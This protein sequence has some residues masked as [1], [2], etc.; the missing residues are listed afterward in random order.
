MRFLLAYSGWVERVLTH[1]GMAAGWLFILN[2]I[3]ICT[4][5][6]TRKYG[7]QI[8]GFGSTRLQE[9]EWHLHAILFSMWMGL[10]YLRNAH[11]RIDLMV[12]GRSV[13]TRAW[14]EFVCLIIFALPY[15][16]VLIDHGFTFAWRSWESGEGSESATGLPMRWIAKGAGLRCGDGH[17]GTAHRLPVR[18]GAPARAGPADTVRGLIHDRLAH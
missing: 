3:V 8:P 9:L 14:I 12:A 17:A 7:F 6:V 16:L 1:I 5:V 11:V 4:D 13:R 18:S 15:C 2:M 10:A